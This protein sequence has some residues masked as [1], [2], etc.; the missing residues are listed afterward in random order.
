[1]TTHHL[2]LHFNVTQTTHDQIYS[3]EGSKM[4]TVTNA[5]TDVKLPLKHAQNKTTGDIHSFIH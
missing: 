3:S 5:I 2:K 1:M 4:T